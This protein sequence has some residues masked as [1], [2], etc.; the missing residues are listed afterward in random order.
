MAEIISS[1]MKSSKTV[2]KAVLE[3]TQELMQ[4]ESG[5]SKKS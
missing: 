5:S 3:K 1:S 4:S 2:Q